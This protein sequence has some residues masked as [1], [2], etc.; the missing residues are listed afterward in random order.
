[1][2]YDENKSSIEES[3]NPFDQRRYSLVSKE[4]MR[5]S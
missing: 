4:E 2:K 5:T 3:K 1:M